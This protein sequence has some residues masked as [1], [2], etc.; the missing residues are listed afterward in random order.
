MTTTRPS[1][2]KHLGQNFLVNPRIITRILDA[3]GPSANDTILEIGA[4]PG[5]MTRPLIERGSRIIAVEK[6]PGLIKTLQ[7]QNDLQTGQLRIIEAD[8]LTL[9]ASDLTGVTKIF[10]NI[11]YNISTPIIEWL[12]KNRAGISAVF[13]MTQLEF[14]QRLTAEPF[15]KD[16]GALTCLIQYFADLEIL[17]KIPNTAFS[18]VPK[19]SSCFLKFTFRQPESRALD[20]DL[21]FTVTRTAFQNRRKKIMNSLGSVVKKEEIHAVFNDCRIDPQLRADQISISDYVQLTNWLVKTRKK[22][23]K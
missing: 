19:V 7:S 6:D 5:A 13:L 8:I 15:S 2:K 11:P 20:E 10:G 14:G 18:P 23:E 1:A 16:Y 21:L 17:F 22:V 9:N 4:G 12:I 3:V